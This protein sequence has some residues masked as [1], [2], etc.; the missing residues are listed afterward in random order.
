[1]QAW[2]LKHLHDAMVR[3]IDACRTP[4]ERLMCRA[5]CG[6]EIRETADRL[7]QTRKLTPGEAAI[8]AE[9]GWQPQARIL[10]SL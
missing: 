8:A 2:N 7:S 3:D 5:I 4:H 6:Q 1:M 10:P 9:H